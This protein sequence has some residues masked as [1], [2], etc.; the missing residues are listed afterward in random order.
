VPDGLA[1]RL[2]ASTDHLSALALEKLNP[3]H[4][5]PILQCA[6]GITWIGSRSRAESEKVMS[7]ALAAPE[8]DSAG[9]SWTP[10]MLRKA[11]ENTRR[12]GYSMLRRARRL[13]NMVA[14]SVV[15]RSGGA[16]AAAIS[17]RLAESAV[18][19][20]AGNLRFAPA[21]SALARRLEQEI[22]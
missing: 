15:V 4:R 2:Q 20:G 22:T 1:L 8:R 10:H 21:L 19:V 13:T 14:L 16:P 6:A 7:A 18:P 5:L 17:V 11:L 12:D 9:T 3:R